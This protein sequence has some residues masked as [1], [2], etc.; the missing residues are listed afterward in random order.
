MSIRQKR[1]RQMVIVTAALILLAW[2][3][4]LCAKVAN[5]N[6]VPQNTACVVSV[7]D[8]PAFWNAWKA[9]AIYQTFLKTLDSPDIGADTEVFNRQLKMIEATLGFPLN[10]ESVSQIIQSVDA[11]V[12]PGEN[13]GQA[14]EGFIFRVKDKP[15]LEKLIDLVEK[16]AVTAAAKYEQEPASE[17]KKETE[18]EK[19]KENQGGADSTDAPKTGAKKATEAP[20]AKESAP[21]EQPS[22]DNSAN[23]QPITREVYN[24]VTVKTFKGSEESP[25]TY[26]AMSGDFLFASNSMTEIKQL[27]DRA[28]GKQ[29]SAGKQATAGKQSGAGEKE[30][31]AQVIADFPDYRAIERGLE[32]K[33]GE[34]FIMANMKQVMEFARAQPQF[35]MMQGMLQSELHEGSQGW[36][37]EFKPKNVAV[38]GYA[39]GVKIENAEVP[40]KPLPP[41]SFAPAT[42]LLVHATDLARPQRIYDLANKL[43]SV[44]MPGGNAGGSMEER[45]KAFETHLGFTIKDDLVPALGNQLGL[46]LN[47]VKMDGMPVVDAALVVQ[48]ADKAK[49][50]KVLAG[51][52]KFVNT[53]WKARTT[54]GKNADEQDSGEMKTERYNETKIKYVEVPGQPGYSPGFAIV[55]DYVILATT[56][57]SIRSMLD[58]K[59]G[60]AA[61]LLSSDSF[62]SLGSQISGAANSLVFLNFGEIWQTTSLLLSSIPGGQSA[63]KIIDSLKVFKVLGAS[64]VIKDNAAVS[65]T[66][67]V[68]Q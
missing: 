68:L 60:K 57:E 8:M 48:I 41:L 23:V 61:S 28:A 43:S 3:Q 13:A 66:V 38:H 9:N 39:L 44:G 2:A 4:C 21:A 67:M 63:G 50:D 32:G 42:S 55:G 52:E 62:K 7:P 34:L 56:R 58:I 16:A 54:Q 33:A 53:V 29:P 35:E 20:A 36:N 31:R 37:V 14:V 40:S 51:T 10:G 12:L 17:K 5:P 26:Y 24:G 59:A 49:M 30:K 22:P 15:K 45:L 6:L 47:A 64:T 27:I 25:E 19:G 11:Y 18:P 1:T 46:F 65:E